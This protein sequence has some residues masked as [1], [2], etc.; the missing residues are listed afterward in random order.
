MCVILYKPKNTELPPKEDLKA[1]WEA[2][3]HGAGFMFPHKNK[4][5]IKKGFMKL[6]HLLEALENIDNIKKIPLVVHF[7]IPTSGSNTKAF[8]HPFPISS[9]PKDLFATEISIDIAIAHN[10]TICGLGDN[11]LSDTQEFIIEYLA[12][13]KKELLNKNKPILKLLE[14]AIGYSKIAIMYSD[15]GVKLIGN[16]EKEKEYYYS[17]LFWK[18]KTLFQPTSNNYYYYRTSYYPYY[19]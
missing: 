18:H 8:T 12:P 15:G 3:P 19:K 10:G 9:S 7:R 5:L 13:L 1:M 17:N 4:V 16:W 14:L 2:N 6:K 11:Y